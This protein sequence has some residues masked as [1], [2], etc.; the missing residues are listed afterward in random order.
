[1]KKKVRLKVKE[2]YLEAAREKCP[3]GRIGVEAEREN[4][5]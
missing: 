3:R 5:S 4:R 1:M 2:T